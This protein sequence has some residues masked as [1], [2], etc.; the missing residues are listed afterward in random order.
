MA[1]ETEESCQHTY[2]TEFMTPALTQPAPSWR[3]SNRLCD[4]IHGRKSAFSI[5]RNLQLEANSEGQL[6]G[7]LRPGLDTTTQLFA[8]KINGSKSR[9]PRPNRP[10]HRCDRTNTSSTCIVYT[11]SELPKRYENSS[12]VILNLTNRLNRD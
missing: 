9:H 1:G 11:V 12:G 8:D 5:D 6:G 10:W 3:A 7:N 2:L 4:L